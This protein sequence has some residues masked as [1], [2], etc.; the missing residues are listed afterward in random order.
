MT[1]RRSNAGG[2]AST[3]QQK[4]DL[5]HCPDR[6]TEV[7]IESRPALFVRPVFFRVSHNSYNLESLA[8]GRVLIGEVFPDRAGIREKA[9]REGLIDHAHRRTARGISRVDLPSLE[10]R[11]AQR[12]EVARPDLCPMRSQSFRIPDRRAL[13]RKVIAGIAT[14]EPRVGQRDVAYAGDPSQLFPHLLVQSCNA[15][16]FVSSRDGIDAYHQ[17]MAAVIAQV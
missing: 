8:S 6:M 15:R 11:N 3:A 7:R 13:E 14:E 5:F 10:Q 1:N 9:P 2:I 4:G 16:S 12:L 17:E